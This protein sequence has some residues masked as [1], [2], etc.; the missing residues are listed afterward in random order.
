MTFEPMTLS[1]RAVSDLSQNF[2]RISF[3]SPRLDQLEPHQP[4]DQRIKLIFPPSSGQL[5]KMKTQDWYQAWLGL[6]ETERGWMRTYSIR[7]LTKD[8]GHLVL[9]VD[10][11]LHGKADGEES[12]PASRWAQDAQVGDEVIGVFP[13][14]GAQSGGIEFAPADAEQILLV[15]DETAAPAIAR[16]LEDLAAGNDTQRTMRGAALIEVPTAADELHINSPEGVQVH[17]LPRNG[18]EYGSSLLP[19]LE[20][21]VAPSESGTVVALDEIEE[22]AEAPLVWET[23][24]YSASGAQL[25]RA[26]SNEKATSADPGAQAG[27]ETSGTTP[28]AEEEPGV[29]TT[30]AAARTFYWI[31]G[32]SGVVK[33][34]RRYLVKECGVKRSDV[35][36]MGYWRIGVAMRG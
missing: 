27:A 12:G 1:T 21:I 9:T 15:G 11:V 30:R 20:E 16:I 35:A 13:T 17:W 24:L 6:D 10:F 33:Q 5:P 8:A 25:D 34:A 36:F 7:E 32:E 26:S 2:R 22:T 28:Q 3:T 29:K 31:A 23:P 18:G 19:A 14:A 4:F